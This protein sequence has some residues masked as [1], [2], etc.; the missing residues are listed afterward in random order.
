MNLLAGPPVPGPQTSHHD[1]A[2]PQ[3]A[4]LTEELA[5]V[6]RWQRLVQ[7]RLD[8]ATDLLSPAD[9]LAA[10]AGPAG[11]P[12]GAPAGHVDLAALVRGHACAD[13]CDVA[14][15]LRAVVSA[16]RALAARA[17]DVSRELLALGAGPVAD[18]T[19]R[20]RCCPGG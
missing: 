14:D 3:R 11:L 17:A 1:G 5:S 16:R 2:G 4:A 10:L 19:H 18:R 7:A 12:L 8:L 6:R 15:D 9:A 13:G 20:R